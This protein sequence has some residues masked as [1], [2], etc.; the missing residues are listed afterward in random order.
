MSTA[1]NNDPLREAEAMIERRRGIAG[2]DPVFRG[3][4]IPVGMVAAMKAQGASSEEITK[5]Y[6][7]LTTRMVDLAEI[8]SAAY[9]AK[10]ATPKLSDL[11][12]KATSSKR[13]SLSNGS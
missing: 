9:P 5:G 2:G 6:P 1:K 4:R 7:A 10:T 3:T 11:G 13:A 12:I 8:W